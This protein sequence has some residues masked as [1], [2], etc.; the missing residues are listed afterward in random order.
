MSDSVCG[1]T[2]V[3]G[4]GI[5][6]PDAWLKATGTA[7]YAGD[8]R[9]PG[10]GLLCGKV[11]RSPHAHADIVSIDTAQAAALEGVY[12][13]VTGQDATLARIGRFIRDRNV[14][15]RGRARH[16][17]EPVAA[18]AAIDEATAIEALSLIRVE[19]SPLP[20][21]LTPKE[22]L[23]PD[24]PII[25]ED[26]AAYEDPTPSRRGGNQR[27]LLTVERG[28]VDGAFA[29]ADVVIEGRFETQP[30]HQG[31]L[32]PRVCVADVD[33]Q[34]LVTLWSSNT[35]PFLLRE[36]VSRGLGL[37]LSK[38]RVRPTAIGGEFGGKGAPT[39]EPICALLAIKAGRAVKIALSTQEELATNFVRHYGVINL[40]L[41]AD[42]NGK[43]LGVEGEVIYNCGAYC[44]AVFGCAQSASSLQG[45][46]NVP[47]VRT[48]GLSIYTNNIPAGHV[49]APSV[50]QP[51]FALESLMDE[52]GRRV[53]LD[54]F[55]IRRLNAL[56]EGD[57]APGGRGVIG[58]GGLLQTI[59]KAADY[60][61][62]NVPERKPNQGLG[63]ACGL[64]MAPSSDQHPSKCIV[65]LNEDGSATLLT[66]M[67]DNGAG[68]HVTLSQVVA[69]ELGLDPA[70]V[71]VVG[72]DT[73]LTPFDSG[74]GASRGTVRVGHSARFAAMDARRQLFALA[75]SELEANS[76]DLELGNRRVFVRGTPD[77]AVSLAA[78]ARVA[79]SSPRGAIVGTGE[80]ERERWLAEQSQR[81]PM[82]VDEAC[83]C[84]HVAQVE[85][86]P[87][88]GRITVLKYAA[89]QD[90]GRAL[91][92][93]N[94][95]GQI[96]GAVVAGLGHSLSEEIVVQEGRVANPTLVDY[97]IPNSDTT[98]AVEP[99]LVEQ[100]TEKG[101][102]GARGI[103]E[104]SITPVAA[105]VANAVYDAVGVRIRDLPITPEKVLRALKGTV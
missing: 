81:P 4:K 15:A 14:L 80:S 9:P 29:R 35:G 78:L 47:A 52:L 33:K 90:V 28:D 99:I 53:G 65:K 22:A 27:N 59:E 72:G 103:G 18:V 83:F 70:E 34:G 45:T 92:P 31:F 91:N 62:R 40:R 25:H 74:P 84:T 69:E 54:P 86:D 97:H 19:Y 63:V 105:A 20:A 8:V 50:P 77:R 94:T 100:P 46:Y 87:E 21:I 96:Q 55:E 12:A 38:V 56:R 32:E 67:P 7:W 57:P 48:R 61:K 39:I 23:A 37:P 95:F 75:A 6:K 41:A 30:V 82:V 13:V 79:L 24:A 89:A 73:E 98:P 51:L 44:D 71:A 66:G 2:R 104:P 85:V 43:L 42:R 16:I 88:T 102:Y 36:M 5:P 58:S 64:F 26:L 11:L 10:P 101:P 76:K 1:G 93:I 49:R 68:Q 17:G 3:I 60:V